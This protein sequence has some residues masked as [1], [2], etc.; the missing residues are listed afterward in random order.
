MDKETMNSKSQ[1]NYGSEM[2]FDEKQT[3]PS[4]PKEVSYIL[5]DERIILKTD[6]GT[7]SYKSLDTGT[8]ILLKLAFEPEIK[9]DLLDLGCV[10]GPISISLAKKFPDRRIWSV[11]VNERSLGLVKANAKSLGINNV[12]PSKPIEAE[13]QKFAAIYSN[14]PIRIGKKELYILLLKWLNRLDDKGVAY[15]VI[16]RNLGADAVAVFLNEKGF[17]TTKVASKQGYRVFKSI[18]DS[19]N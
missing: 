1:P 2:Y 4:N 6:R 12:F 11:D 5:D 3:I 9:G 13:N 10:Y 17:F 18:R 8:K 7:F 16:K 19:S 14:P 15:L